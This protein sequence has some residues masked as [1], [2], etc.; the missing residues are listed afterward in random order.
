MA[1]T[2]S[3]KDTAYEYLKE[4][5]DN[6][7]LLPD[8]HLKEVEIAN[9]LGMSRTPVRRAM[10]Q[11]EEE[12]YV[13]IEPYKGAVV[14][15]SSL[16]STAIVERLQFVE[17]M[18]MHLFQH[19]QNKDIHVDKEEL[20]EIVEEMERG[21]ESE[22]DATY[23][24]AEFK[25]FRFLA[26][27]HSNSYFRQ[28]GLSTIAPLHELYLKNVKADQRNFTKE[29]NETSDVYPEFIRAIE[30]ADYPN[31]RKQVRIWMN[32]LILNQINS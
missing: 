6:N 7:I 8:T 9:K 2:Q 24:A 23:Y 10:A 14:I 25:L 1:K 21:R 4:R 11:L 20:H 12:G 27:Y 29:R 28:I 5:I 30:E 3:Y 16:T 18:A 15:K 31:A 32:Q 13:K 19:M 26:F 17:L 22:D